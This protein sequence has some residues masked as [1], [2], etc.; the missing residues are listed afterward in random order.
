MTIRQS[1]AICD[2]GNASGTLR[3]RLRN[4]HVTPVLTWVGRSL[5]P[6]LST[7]QPLLSAQWNGVPLATAAVP[8]VGGAMYLAMSAHPAGLFH[9]GGGAAPSRGPGW[10]A[11]RA[12]EV[13]SVIRAAAWTWATAPPS[14]PSTCLSASSRTTARCSAA[15]SG[16]TTFLELLVEASAGRQPII[17][18]DPKGSP[19]LAAAVRAQGGM[20]WTLDGSLSADLLA[21][22]PW[23]V[24]DLLLEAKV[25]SPEARVFRDAAHLIGCF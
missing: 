10:G 19:A 9:G 24:P 11:L 1:L 15:L 22:R 20:F 18:V 5:V 2:A 8:V 12:L 13:A 21:P 3:A 6:D 7:L 4:A 17:L 25:D 23:Q 14:A 16:K